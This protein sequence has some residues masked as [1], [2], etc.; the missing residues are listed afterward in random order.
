MNS[1]KSARPLPYELSAHGRV[2]VERFWIDFANTGAAGAH[3]YVH[4]GAFRTDGPWRYTV[5]AGKSL[6]DYWQAGRSV[7]GIRAVEPAGAV[8]RRFA[9]S[10][11]QPIA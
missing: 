9:A 5:E 8:V 1:V 11:L 6:S 10:V 3:F 7:E 4:A 2:T